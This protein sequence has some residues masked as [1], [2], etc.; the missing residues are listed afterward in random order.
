MVKLNL[1]NGTIKS[2]DLSDET[3]CRELNT[4]GQCKDFISQVTGFWLT[5]GAFEN[6]LPMPWRFSRVFFYAEAIYAKDG[7]YKG[8]RLE[9]YADNVKLILTGYLGSRFTR[10]NLDR[11]GKQ[12]FR[13]NRG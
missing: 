10:V 5:T 13:P 12:R 4:L 7:E 11:V 1:R 8:D 3:Q 2:F 9:V 6:T